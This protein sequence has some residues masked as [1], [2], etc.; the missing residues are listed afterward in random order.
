[1]GLIDQRVCPR[2]PSCLRRVV[3]SSEAYPLAP[4]IWLASQPAPARSPLLLLL[5]QRG[6]SQRTMDGHP[7]ALVDPALDDGGH[8]LAHPPAPHLPAG[9][10][11]P[12]HLLHQAALHAS[13]QPQQPQQQQVDEGAYLFHP[14][15]ADGDALHHH[16][17]ALDALPDPPA[18]H[19]A[20]P[21]G[22]PTANDDGS[23]SAAAP[24]PSADAP[25]ADGQPATGPPVSVR[26]PRAPT[27]PIACARCRRQ[28]LKCSGG[29]PC[30]RCAKKGLRADEDGGC[31]YV[32]EVRRRGLGKKNRKGSASGGGGGGEGSQG[33]GSQQGH[34][35][36][37]VDGDGHALH[38]QHHQQHQ[39]A[40]DGHYPVQQAHDYYGPSAQ[41]HDAYGADSAYTSGPGGA[42]GGPSGPAQDGSDGDVGGGGVGDAHLL[43]LQQQH[44]LDSQQQQA[45]PPPTT[46]AAPGEPAIDPALETLAHP[47]AG[48]PL[49]GASTSGGHDGH[50]PALPAAQAP[51][52][53]AFSPTSIQALDLLD[54]TRMS[55]DELSL[56]PSPPDLAPA[57][58][59]LAG[60]DARVLPTPAVRTTAHSV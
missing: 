5:A 33:E 2:I 34:G 32:A 4:P 24:P 6:H 59:V 55:A 13:Y 11:H 25:S 9:G 42:D 8:S 40:L 47:S 57:P 30:V 56:R 35:Q 51:P 19:L 54:F 7:V 31:E 28:K 29:R 45:R 15:P 50:Q 12:Q 36:G 10:G 22:V 37:A 41:A 16:Q 53:L 20:N 23:P 52:H 60:T 21:N 18:H 17:A 26:A 14:G 58:R 1:M 39:Q 44:E 48:A 46:A 49:S 38:H 27:I 43:L 3:A